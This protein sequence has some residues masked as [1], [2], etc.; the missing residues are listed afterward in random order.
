MTRPYDG[1]SA[2]CSWANGSR[3]PGQLLSSGRARRLPQAG[4]R[5][6]RRSG[7]GESG[8]RHVAGY[9]GEGSDL[10]GSFAAGDVHDVP[11]AEVE[12]NTGDLDGE[13]AVIM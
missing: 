12:R 4:H 6:G 10:H 1:T 2:P 13:V 5:G 3:S 11:V 8:S 7:L 9:G